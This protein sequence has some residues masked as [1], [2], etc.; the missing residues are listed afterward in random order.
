MTTFLDR[1][2]SMSCS[3]SAYALGGKQ[4]VV[5]A[6]GSALFAVALPHGI[7]AKESPGKH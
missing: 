1:P 5:I 4:Y 6:A 2:H 3:P 7:L